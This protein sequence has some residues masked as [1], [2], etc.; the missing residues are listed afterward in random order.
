MLSVSMDEEVMHVQ[1]E[2]EFLPTRHSLLSRLKD[3]QDNESWREFFDLYWKLIYNAA[4]KSGLS[5]VEAQD[6]VQET[7]VSVHKSMPDF[8]YNPKIGSFKTWLLN[9]TRWRVVDV[10]RKRTKAKLEPLP[11]ESDV[12]SDAEMLVDPTGLK[13]EEI[14]EQEWQKNLVDAAIQKVRTKIDPRQYQIFD[15]YVMQQQP[16][17]KVAEALNVTAAKVYLAKFRVSNLIKKE[18]RQLNLDQ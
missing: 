16:L 14:W 3:A 11:D 8:K 15:L 9:L 13:L 5:E 6:V 1:R 12:G 2:D 17:K 10:V 7:I 18:L 4:R